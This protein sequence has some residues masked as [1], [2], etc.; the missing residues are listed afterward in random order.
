M[1][2]HLGTRYNKKLILV[3]ELKSSFVQYKYIVDVTYLL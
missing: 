2:L 3:L 1:S